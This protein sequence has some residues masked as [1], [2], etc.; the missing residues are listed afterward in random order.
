MEFEKIYDH[1]DDLDLE[2]RVDFIAQNRFR[3]GDYG[4]IPSAQEVEFALKLMRRFPQLVHP[5][6][7]EETLDLLCEMYMAG[8]T[9][10]REIEDFMFSVV[11]NLKGNDV[12]AAFTVFIC[13]D[14]DRAREKIAARLT[15][16]DPIERQIAAD[17]LQELNE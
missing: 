2:E 13:M 6:E 1:F 11:D 3:V 15:S 12:D 16:A 17:C 10:N 9:L 14:G 7:I 8:P 5:E 4:V